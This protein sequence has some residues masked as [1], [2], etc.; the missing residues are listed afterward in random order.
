LI[1]RDVEASADELAAFHRL[2]QPLFQ[3]RE[4]RTWSAFYLCGQL[5]NLEHKTIEA[6][7]LTLRGPDVNAVRGLQQF[8]GQG[9]WAAETLVI[10]GQALVAEW[11]GEPDGVVI[12]D[13]S[14]FPKRGPYSVGVAPQYCG[15]LGK[16][17]NCQQGVF[18]VYAATRGYTFLD[19]RL[20]LPECWFGEAYRER[21]QRGG[22]PKAI[23]FQTEPELGVEMI[24]D[25]ASRG[26]VPFRWVTADETYGKSPTFLDGIA[27]LN[28]WYLVEVPSDTRVWLH[29]PPVEPPGRGLMGPPRTRPRVARNAP[30]PREVRELAIRLPKLKWTRRVIKE[31]NQGPL[32][33]EFAFLRATAIREGLPGPRVWVIFRRTWR[34]EPEIKFYFS[35]A[36]TT[37]PRNEF[38]RV[39]GLRWPVETALEEGKGEIGMDHYETR[40]WL[41]WHHHMAH[42]FLAHLFLMRLRLSLQKKSGPDHR[43][44]PSVGRSGHRGRQQPLARYF[45]DHPLPSTTQPCRL[46][47]PSQAH[48][49]APSPASFWAAKTQSL[50]VA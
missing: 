31:G 8:I 44:S 21:W 42:T 11:F 33:A 29:T 6:M 7:V 16:V 10:H 3:R 30:Q 17:A 5:A 48:P 20:Y 2:F 15:H 28:K 22:I 46:P 18:L 4:Q 24:R 40:S 9:R 34:P 41:G 39:S 23:R 32:V 12:V 26:V 1:Q 49:Q 45:G 47:F 43:P 36:P 27:A 13:G 37:C 35:N 19:E 25:L 38:I 50:V 14:G